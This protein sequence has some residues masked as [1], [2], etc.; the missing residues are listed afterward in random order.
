MIQYIVGN[1]LINNGCCWLA[2]L[3][4]GKGRVKNQR[5]LDLEAHDLTNYRVPTQTYPLAMNK[6]IIHAFPR[7]NHLDVN[8]LS[9]STTVSTGVCGFSSVSGQSRHWELGLCTLFANQCLKLFIRPETHW[10]PEDSAALQDCSLTLMHF[11][12]MATRCQHCNLDKALNFY[13][14]FL[15]S[16]FLI[17]SRAAC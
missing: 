14:V 9:W 10:L 7:I 8:L 16:L 6:E 11:S 2:S 5:F 13:L 15:Y 17:L 1:R 4:T 12:I 3:F